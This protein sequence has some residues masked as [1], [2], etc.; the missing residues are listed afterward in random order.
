VINIYMYI[1][2]NKLT[3][4][5]DTGKSPGVSN[6]LLLSISIGTVSKRTYIII[7][8]YPSPNSAA[9][10]KRRTADRGQYCD[11]GPMPRSTKWSNCCDCIK[12]GQN[13]EAETEA[14]ALRWTQGRSQR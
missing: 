10:T 4:R 11:S 5:C 7:Y 1:C 8:H 3:Q 13:L 12:R 9:M 14:R 6:S 2:Q